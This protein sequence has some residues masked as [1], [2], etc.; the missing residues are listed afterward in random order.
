MIKNTLLFGKS[1][2]CVVWPVKPCKHA[3]STT[4]ARIK[5][6]FGMVVCHKNVKRGIEFGRYRLIF[7]LIIVK[8]MDVF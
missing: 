5:L 2:N 8:K 1:G 6:K 3:K 4:P 7:D